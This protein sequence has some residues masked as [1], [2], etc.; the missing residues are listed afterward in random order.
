MYFLKT[1]EVLK[2]VM[3]AGDMAHMRVKL[4]LAGFTELQCVE[5]ESSLLKPFCGK[6]Y[7]FVWEFS[8]I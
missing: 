4:Y 2:I 5:V 3:Q 1:E 8:Y 7:E 6:A